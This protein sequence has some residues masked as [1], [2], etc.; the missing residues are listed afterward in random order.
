MVKTRCVNCFVQRQSEPD[1]V[2]SHLC[3]TGNVMR[4]MFLIRST[5]A[6]HCLCG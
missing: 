4:I 5:A 1:V 2:N 6:V 3:D